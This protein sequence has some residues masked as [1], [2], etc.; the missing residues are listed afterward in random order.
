M[1][2][3]VFLLKNLD[4]KEPYGMNEGIKVTIEFFKKNDML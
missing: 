3:P 2:S 4:Y 1:T